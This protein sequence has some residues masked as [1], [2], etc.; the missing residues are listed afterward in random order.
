MVFGNIRLSLSKY[1]PAACSIIYFVR[2][3]QFR[4]SN[5]L[6]MSTTIVSTF[7]CHDNLNTLC[8]L[9]GWS[10]DDRG[11]VQKPNFFHVSIKNSSLKINF[12]KKQIDFF[13]YFVRIWRNR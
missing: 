10:F 6:L 5:M 9:F 7:D 3:A 8:N 4:N 12:L 2:F 1:L 11:K 13:H